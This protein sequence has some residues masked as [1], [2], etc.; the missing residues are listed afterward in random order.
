MLDFLKSTLFAVIVVV[1]V[2]IIAGMAQVSIGDGAEKAVYGGVLGLLA[3][4]YWQQ[5]RLNCILIEG[6]ADIR[7]VIQKDA[8]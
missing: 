6:L 4:M 2:A 8:E 3:A 7:R 5:R 1:V